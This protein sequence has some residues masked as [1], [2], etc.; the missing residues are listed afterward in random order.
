MLA[1]P[2]LRALR[3][4]FAHPYQTWYE[5]A[6]KAT[7]IY[8]Q[9][10]MLAPI[11]LTNAAAQLVLRTQVRRKETHPL[12]TSTPPPPLRGLRGIVFDVTIRCI[13]DIHTTPAPTRVER[14]VRTSVSNLEETSM[15]HNITG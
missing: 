14:S 3:D 4:R 12:P 9:G 10:A 7:T 13:T 5:C 2:P 11:R 15:Y 6:V 8:Q 1:S